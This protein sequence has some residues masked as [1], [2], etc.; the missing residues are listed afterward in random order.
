MG[1]VYK[2]RTSGSIVQLPI[3]VLPEPSR[4]IRAKSAIR[5]RSQQAI[6]ALN[7]PHICT[8]H[9]VGRDTTGRSRLPGHRVSRR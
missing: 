4:P 8:L 9:D 6:A 7:H 2:A 3:K 5:A 1:E